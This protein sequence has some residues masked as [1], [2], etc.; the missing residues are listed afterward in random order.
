[1]CGTHNPA[2]TFSISNGLREKVKE[3]S[4]SIDGH[5]SAP[6]DRVA[7]ALK[8]AG[9]S[10]GEITAHQ[11][12]GAQGLLSHWSST[13][14]SAA[15]QERSTRPTASSFSAGPAR[16]AGDGRCVNERKMHN[17]RQSPAD[18]GECQVPTSASRAITVHESRS[19][20]EALSCEEHL[21]PLAWTRIIPKLLQSANTAHLPIPSLSHSSEA[22]NM[23]IWPGGSVRETPYRLLIGWPDCYTAP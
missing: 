7:V 11:S 3:L 21:G 17:P 15:V 4:R 8:R 1:M 14:L 20:F 5:L 16:F 9:G 6:E 18:S 2:G 19:G 10:S 12:R 23:P 13:D 22:A